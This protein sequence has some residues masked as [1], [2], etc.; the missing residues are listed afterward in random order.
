MKT[1]FKCGLASVI[2]Y[3]LF[4][5]SIAVLVF[6]LSNVPF[7]L[8]IN[9]IIVF[10]ILWNGFICW[11]LSKSVK[12]GILGIVAF[13]IPFL[14]IAYWGYQQDKLYEQKQASSKNAAEQIAFEDV[15]LEE[16]GILD[17]EGFLT[18][19]QLKLTFKSNKAFKMRFPFKVNAL[20]SIYPRICKSLT[21]PFDTRTYEIKE[22]FNSIDVSLP[23][24]SK[25]SL[26]LK[27]NQ[28][29]FAIKLN[30]SPV[31]DY[32]YFVTNV[33]P[34][35]PVIVGCGGEKFGGFLTREYKVR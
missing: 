32:I 35:E 14:Y 7:V 31:T 29:V 8:P 13:S 21:L 6:W 16:N 2:N 20:N 23:V 22:G 17:T 11:K 4:Q 25:E 9:F 12:W 34:R 28:T 24:Q 10:F 3:L 1:L 30:Y 27:S 33:K 26:A 15:H 19:L 5:F 18:A